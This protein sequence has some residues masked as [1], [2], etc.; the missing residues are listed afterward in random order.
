M[1]AEQWSIMT[2]TQ[3]EQWHKGQIDIACAGSRSR[4]EVRRKMRTK[5]FG[6][7]LTPYYAALPAYLI[8]P[9][10]EGEGP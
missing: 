10:E 8:L 3:R 4:S 9:E 5:Q 1:N 2:K 7:D 6:V